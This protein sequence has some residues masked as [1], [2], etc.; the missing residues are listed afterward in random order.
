MHYRAMFTSDKYFTSADLYDERADA[1][2]ELT[3]TIEKVAKVTMVGEKGK[4]DGRPGLWFVGSKLGKPLG[5]NAGNS[6]K[7]AE[8]AGST[9]VK[10]WV[11]VTI[12]LVVEMIVIRGKGPHPR[13]AVRV[14]APR[15]D[16]S[17]QTAP[18]ISA[19]EQAE[20][21]RIE[22]EERAR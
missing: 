12:R 2:R 15:G 1:F 20:I 10:K 22:R 4:T 8:I 13:P 16:A 14:K 11:G 17:A 7:M 3:V 18:D 21:E 6:D 5:L 19:D 9:D